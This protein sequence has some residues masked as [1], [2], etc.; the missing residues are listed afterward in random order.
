[1][2]EQSLQQEA[3]PTAKSAAHVDAGDAGYSKSLKS[4]HVN[5]IEA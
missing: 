1:M 3:I 4:R 2:S 5:M